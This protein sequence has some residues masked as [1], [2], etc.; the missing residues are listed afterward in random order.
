LSARQIIKKET[1]PA[2]PA[3]AKR[4][5]NYPSNAAILGCASLIKTLRSDTHRTMRISGQVNGT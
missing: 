4:A 2:R 1:Q 5:V 3:T